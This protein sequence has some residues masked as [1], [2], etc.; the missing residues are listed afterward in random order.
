MA[1]IAAV[2][3]AAGRSSR[4]RAA[5][6]A[7]ETKLVAKLEG[8]PIVRRVVK[9]A[10][11]SRASSVIV[12]VGHARSA[13][14][15]AVA[16][17]PTAIAFN[18]DFATGIASSLRTG[19]AATP[20]ETDGAVV[21]LGDMPNVAPHLIDRLIDAFEARPT[22]LA[23]APIREGRRGNPVLVARSLFEQAMGLSGDEGAR[24]LLAALDR[25]AVAEIAAASDVSFDVD[26]P[27]D[28]ARAQPKD[29]QS[30]KNS[31]RPDP[32]N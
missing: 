4:F 13:V 14:E 28:L 32:G 2:V 18:S 26:T 9:A 10:L 29:A 12:V 30:A 25:G 19:L 3:L 23:V 1:R 17:L 8:E 27:A 7:E 5:G 21:L 20:A 24:R 16:G 15:A 6:G 22:L 11:A 31:E